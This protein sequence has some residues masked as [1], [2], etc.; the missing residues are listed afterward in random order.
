MF[1]TAVGAD[2]ILR[3]NLNA[4]KESRPLEG[5]NAATNYDAAMAA[6]GQRFE[7]GA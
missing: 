3:M 7:A 1:V 2:L 5:T 4:W 6:I